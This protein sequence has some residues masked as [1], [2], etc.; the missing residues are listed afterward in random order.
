MA[1]RT[2]TCKQLVAAAA[3]GLLDPQ[4]RS[5]AAAVQWWEL[6]GLAGQW[7][8]AVLGQGPPLLMLHGFDSSFLEFR[9]LV[10]LL[11]D[12]YQLFIPDLFGFGFCPRPEPAHSNPE[13]VLAHLSSLVDAIGL[14]RGESS[15]APMGLMGASMG[16]SVAVELARLRPERIARL[17]LLAPAGLTGKPMPLPPL[18]DRL[19]VNF[20]G[21]PGVRKGLCSSAFA[22][23]DRDV[24]PAELEI[25]SLHLSAPG[26]A[27]TLASFARSGGFAGCG[28]PLPQQPLAVLWGANDRILRAPQ[29]RAALALLGDRVEE[30][31]ACGHLP[32]IDQPARVAHTWLSSQACP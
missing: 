11:A 32:H 26:W 10:P 27:P 4:G 12:N 2:Q 16:G 24:G 19:G 23:P 18:L 9:R 6:S 15:P 7:P 30:L 20:L 3:A 31:E 8:V 21:L 29:K 1:D 14:H 5:L 13:A 17:L 28:S 22:D 25:A